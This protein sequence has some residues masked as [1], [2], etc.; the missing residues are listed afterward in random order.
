MRLSSSKFPGAGHTRTDLS[1]AAV[2]FW[3]VWSFMVIYDPE[4]SPVEILRVLHGAR[5]L[6][7]LLGDV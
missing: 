6:G 5:N 7:A 3:P 1:R 2:R 4:T